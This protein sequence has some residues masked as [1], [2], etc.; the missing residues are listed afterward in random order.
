MSRSYESQLERRQHRHLRES[1]A[2]VDEP[3]PSPLRYLDF[4]RVVLDGQLRRRPRRQSFAPM[5]PPA[6]QRLAH[7]TARVAASCPRHS[8][9]S[10][11]SPLARALPTPVAT[12]LLSTPA[13]PLSVRRVQLSQAPPCHR[14]RVRLHL[15]PLRTVSMAAGVVLLVLC[16]ALSLSGQRCRRR[17]AAAPRA[18]RCARWSLFIGGQSLGRPSSTARLPISRT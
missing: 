11:A 7:G 5:A 1:V 3:H 16:S 17:P 15:A 10:L 14:A 12:A 9:Q 18:K 13:S 6:W 2:Q 8:P 4:W